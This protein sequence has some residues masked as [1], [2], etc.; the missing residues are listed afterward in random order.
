MIDVGDTAVDAILTGVGS[1]GV[2]STIRGINH[3]SDQIKN[4][5]DKDVAILEGVEVAITGTVKGI[6]DTAELAYNVA[7]SAPSRAVG[8]GLCAVTKFSGK[9]IGKAL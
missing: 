5:A 3:S 8:R 1:L 4:G 2:F 7:S 6:V 9:V